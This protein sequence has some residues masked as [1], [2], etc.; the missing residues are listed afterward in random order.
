MSSAASRSASPGVR[1]LTRLL[2]ALGVLVG[3]AAGA[4]AIYVSSLEIDMLRDPIAGQLSRALGR[5]VSIARVVEWGELLRPRLVLEEVVVSSTPAEGGVE[6]ARIERAVVGLDLPSLLRGAVHVESVTTQGVSLTIDVDSEGHWIWAAAR[7]G[8][9]RPSAPGMDVAIDAVAVERAL[10]TYRDSRSGET[11]RLT[12]E[13]LSFSLDREGVEAE[14][15]GD[16]AGYAVELKGEFI[17][18]SGSTGLQGPFDGSITGRIDDVEVQLR[19]HVG[20][21]LELD[22]LDLAISARGIELPIPSEFLGGLALAPATLSGRLEAKGGALSLRDLALEASGAAQGD[23]LRLSGEVADLTG[24]VEVDLEAVFEG[25]DRAILGPFVSQVPEDFERLRVNA[26]VRGH[27]S[28]LDL[29]EVVLEL[30]EPTSA[31]LRIEGRLS[32]LLGRRV[33]EGSA[34][35]E[36]EDARFLHPALAGRP[37]S[38][39]GAAQLRTAGASFR[40]E[41]LELELAD[42]AGMVLS[43]RGGVHGSADV[44]ELDLD[45]ELRAPKLRALEGLMGRE[46]PNLGPVSGSARLR[47]SGWDVDAEDIDVEVGGSGGL[48]VIVAGD[49]RDLGGQA[50]ARLRVRVDAPSSQPIAE[51]LERDLPALGR[52]EVRAA[53]DASKESVRVEAVSIETA[54]ADG[55]SFSAQGEIHGDSLGDEIDL[56]FE[57]HSPQ[58]TALGELADT[59]LPALGPVR[60]SG[61]LYASNDGAWAIHGMDAHLGGTDLAGSV[62][63]TVGGGR[64]SLVADLSARTVYLDDLVAPPAG[65]PQDAVTSWDAWQRELPPLPDLDLDLALRVGALEGRSGLTIEQVSLRARLDDGVLTLQPLA[66]QLEGT[67]VQL[68]GGV[69][70]RS[71]PPRIWLR[72]RGE[73]VDLAAVAA[74]FTDQAVASG[75]ARVRADL[76]SQGRTPTELL[77]SLG[78]EF[79][80]VLRDGRIATGAVVLL[81]KHLLQALA[82]KGRV[83]EYARAE[84]LVADFDLAQGVASTRTL[85]LDGEHTLLHGRGSIDLRTGTL[86]LLITPKA[87][88][89][90]LF[91]VQLPVDVT[92]RYD[93]PVVR[94]QK[95]SLASTAAVAFVGNL[96]IPGVGLLAPFVTVGSLGS[97]PCSAAIEAFLET[98]PEGVDGGG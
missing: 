93:D 49:A 7:G 45:V 15:L 10:V 68:R 14:L 31:G 25:P 2:I 4:L 91:A 27:G 71:T 74:Q 60:A 97:D 48:R 26:R 43:L 40:L 89:P 50:D 35:F 63:H 52:V 12:L 11:V 77:G 85:L 20:T 18:R 47:G 41:D 95:R 13:H 16:L 70:T 17:P 84:C 33:F 8:A 83:P 36:A 28:E 5:D 30:G 92:G 66:L 3:L 88:T 65:G 51:W 42:R 44:L 64:R 79:S 81:Q 87:K 56:T 22:V 86:D 78:G 69:D 58:L 59:R 9:R 21:L 32:D 96:L 34:T 80:L 19:G 73:E 55:L 6:L 1:R 75:Q 38:L 29:D 94:T 62:T 98:R 54:R 24:L 53:L 37:S 61:R 76:S 23:G 90:R 57:L 46:L 82:F 67:P 72:V 39:R